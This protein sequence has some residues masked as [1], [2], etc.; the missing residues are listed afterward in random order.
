MKVHGMDSIMMLIPHLE[1]NPIFYNKEDKRSR[2][3][4]KGGL[5]IA[6]KPPRLKGN[7]H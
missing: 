7:N 4:R 2:F 3:L 5:F 1:Y 6:G